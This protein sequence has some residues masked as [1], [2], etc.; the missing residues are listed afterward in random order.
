MRR[1]RRRDV[2]FAKGTPPTSGIDFLRTAN[3]FL[4]GIVRTAG[5]DR[6]GCIVLCRNRN[7]R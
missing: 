6:I 2:R 7:S 4:A 3:R 1:L 5:V